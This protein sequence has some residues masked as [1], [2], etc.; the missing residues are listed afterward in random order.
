MWGGSDD[1][2]SV[3][4]I[5]TAIER[6]I[7]LIDPAPVYGFGRSEEIVGRALERCGMRHE[8]T[9]ATQAGLNWQNGKPFRDASRKRIF[10]EV[11]PSLKRLRTDFIDLY[12]VHWPDPATP[13]EETAEAMLEL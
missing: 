5:Q 11:E 8:V 3:S 10:A 2:Q 6:G 12:Q 9:V 1:N 13:V 4:T 7:T